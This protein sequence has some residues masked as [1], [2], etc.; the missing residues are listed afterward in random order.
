MTKRDDTGH[1]RRRELNMFAQ[2]I[3][4]GWPVTPE[5]VRDARRLIVEVEADQ[6][7]TER[8][9]AAAERLRAIIEKLT[10]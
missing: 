1:H 9:R 3:R 8:E 7:A 5:R 2:A 10:N 4:N 6:N